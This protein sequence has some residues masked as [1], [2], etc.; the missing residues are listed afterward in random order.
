MILPIVA[1]G[2]PILKKRASEISKP[3]PKLDETILNMYES[4]YGAHGV[5]LAAP[6][7]GLSIR[8]FLVDTSPFA[9]DEEYSVE[10]QE[11]LKD[12]KRTFI[13]AKIIEETGVEWSFNEGCLSIPNVR[14]EVLRKPVIKVE[15][16][17]ENFNT[18]TETFDGLIA[19]VIQH[20]Y[21]HIEGILFTDKVST[22]KKRLLKGKLSNIS[23]GKTSVDYRMR[24]PNMSK[25]RS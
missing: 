6:Q 1:Y 17:D 3:T 24:F 16:L 18:H 25:K 22:L 10:E 13:N 15:Y 19:R 2:D 21:D 23:K 20:E 5:G 8:L 9:D 11:K 12:F 7:V 14:E 4:M